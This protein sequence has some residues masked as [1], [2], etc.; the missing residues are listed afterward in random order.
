MK[1]VLMAI[2]LLGSFAAQTASADSDIFYG[3]ENISVSTSKL[4]E[5]L[6]E[7]IGATVT[8]LSV[9]RPID[10]I[11]FG[12][13]RVPEFSVSFVINS[14]YEVTCDLSLSKERG[15]ALMNL[16]E[17]EPYADFSA[18]VFN[19]KEIGTFKVERF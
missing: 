6:A 3:D 5:K 18:K 4:Q 13:G 15:T 10:E 11:I 19:I 16:C 8:D 1:R 14:Q 2:I 12:A 17:S 7:R 9:S